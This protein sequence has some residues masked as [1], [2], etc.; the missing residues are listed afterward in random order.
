MSVINR[1]FSYKSIHK[2]FMNYF[3]LAMAAFLSS[4]V[5]RAY[6]S[7]IELDECPINSCIVRR[8]VFDFIRSL[9]NKCRSIYA[10]NLILFFLATLVM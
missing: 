10:L 6:A 2:V 9:L 8:F 3:L 5:T 1:C 7:V 4:S